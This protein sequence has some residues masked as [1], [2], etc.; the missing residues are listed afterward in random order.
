[1]K[2]PWNK[3]MKGYMAGEKNNMYGKKHTKQARSKMAMA[4]MGVTPS[5]ET[6]KKMSES[7]KA[8]IKER[9]IT[10]QDMV[11]RFGGVS[12]NRISPTQVAYFAG[13][14]DGEGSVMIVSGGGMHTVYNEDNKYK[15][16]VISTSMVDKEPLEEGQ[17]YFGGSL[18]LRPARD[19][20]RAYWQ[21]HINSG[22][23]VD[24]FL[25]KIRKYVK[26]KGDRIDLAL[27]YRKRL[28]SKISIEG[29]RLLT[30]EELGIRRIIEASLKALNKRGLK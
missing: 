19:N 28:T 7:H 13:L 12:P 1:M 11:A 18:H 17:K 8:L 10:P 3:G 21:W 23:E 30:E 2:T 26:I 6:R 24:Y 25:K 9:G 15:K 4:S 22:K 27:Q 20:G 14:F 16:V 5:E 29:R